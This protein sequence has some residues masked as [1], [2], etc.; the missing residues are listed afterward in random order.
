MINDLNSLIL[1]GKIAEK[2]DFDQRFG[3]VNFHLAVSRFYKDA[4]GNQQEEIFYFEA[5][6]Y[7]SLADIISRHEAGDKLRIVGKLRQKRWKNNGGITCSSVVITVDHA[8]FK[9]KPEPK[10][11]F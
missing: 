3:V 5:E 11:M 8:E 7:G 1:E 4:D 9:P 6:A 2:P 10:E